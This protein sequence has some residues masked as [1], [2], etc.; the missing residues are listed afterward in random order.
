MNNPEKEE[1]ERERE[2]IMGTA[3]KRNAV[4]WPK[5]L[6]LDLAIVSPGCQS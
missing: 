2:S 4:I 6:N 1:R 5:G 3:C